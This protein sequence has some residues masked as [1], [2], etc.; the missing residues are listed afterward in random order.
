[1]FIKYWKEEDLLLIVILSNLRRT[2]P[3]KAKKWGLISMM[4]LER[5]ILNNWKQWGLI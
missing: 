5:I 2:R 4:E 1:M 3:I